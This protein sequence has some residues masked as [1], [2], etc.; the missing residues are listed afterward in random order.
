MHLPPFRL[1]QSVAT[2]SDEFSMSLCVDSSL[3]LELVKILKEFAVK[4]GK[5]II[6]V[7]HQPSS[8]V[9]EMFDKL[10]LMADGKMVYFGDRANVVPYFAGVG[11]KCR[12]L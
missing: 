7:I 5:T 9:F 10:L 8:Q 2:R 12:E 3:A 4:R 6:M 1:R 11:Y